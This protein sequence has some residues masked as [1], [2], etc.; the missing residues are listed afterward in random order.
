MVP[1]TMAKTNDIPYGPDRRPWRETLSKVA[2]L[3]TDGNLVV[4]PPSADPL[5]R[6][7]FVTTSGVTD[8]LYQ[9][10]ST[11]LTRKQHDK[12]IEETENVL[13][14][15]SKSFLGFMH[16]QGF[17]SPPSLQSPLGS[18]FAN[19]AFDPFV[20]GTPYRHNTKWMER[21]VLDYFASLWNAK[22][23]HDPSDPESYWGYVLTMGSTEGNMHAM[24][25][26]RDYLSGKYIQHPRSAL[27]KSNFRFV[28]GKFSSHN[29]NNAV[30]V[31]FY[32]QNSNFSLKKLANITSLQ[33][34]DEIGREKYPNE[35]PLGGAWEEGVPCNGG[36]SGPGCVDIDALVKLVH[37][38]SSKGHPVAVVFNV[39]TTMKGACDDVQNAGERLVAILKK[40]NMYERTIHDP[41]NASAYSV[42]KGFWF[43][44]DGALSAAY[45]PFHEMAYKTGLT[46]IK[47]GP[48]FDFRLD[49]VASIVTSGH[50]YIGTPQPSGVY[51][52]R[53]GMRLSALTSTSIFG[54]YDTTISLSRNAHS[55]IL[56]WSYIS[57]TPY[58][59]QIQNL[60]QCFNMVQY[61]IEKLKDLERKIGIDL[62][63]TNFPPSLSILLRRPNVP[64]ITKYT[65]STT[66]MHIN[67]EERQYAQIYIMR[68]VSKT[69]IDSFIKDLQEQ[70]AFETVSA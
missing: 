16:T 28:Q 45:M 20:V 55:A 17:V 65:L 49:Y 35:N 27:S 46:V 44:V 26:A 4:T 64:L 32:S 60:L 6:T 2:V 48:T 68:N 8:A 47:P 30:P 38:F 62:W 54:C 19:S 5:K 40:N 67:S 59:A 66:T 51:I 18:V 57:T 31:L 36:D 42:R 52:M 43:H 41:D 15:A 1:R 50:K 63:I 58:D 21:N 70:G 10:P 37:F 53:N 39:G 3:S 22:W 13:T 56:L 29:P 11:G 24:W 14:A 25:S 33:T 12:A 9:V 69:K 34:F 7:S 61:A 23:P